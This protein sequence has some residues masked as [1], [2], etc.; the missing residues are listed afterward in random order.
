MK[1]VISTLSFLTL[2]AAAPLLAQKQT[3]IISVVEYAEFLDGANSRMFISFPNG[4]Q[5]EVEMKGLFAI[6]GYINEKNIKSNDNTVVKKL[7]ELQQ[8][9][10]QI[11][12]IASVVRPK[13][14]TGSN[15]PPSCFITRYVLVK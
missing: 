8:Q 13:V 9:G 5:E 4:K 3:M 10:W 15:N 2:L 14:N 11:E 7:N 1:K 12:S 6:S